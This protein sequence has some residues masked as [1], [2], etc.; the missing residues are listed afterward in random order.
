MQKALTK[1][2]LIY[3]LNGIFRLSA[4]AD[5]AFQMLSDG[6]YVK[7]YT[8]DLNA[9]MNDTDVHVDATIKAILNKITADDQGNIYYDTHLLC[10]VSTQ[11]GNAIQQLPD[12][13]FVTDYSTE[14]QQHTDHTNDNEIHV[15]QLDKDTW[16]QML[17]D[18]KVFTLDEIQKLKILEIRPVSTLPEEDD[19][20]ETTIYL[21]DNDPECPEG[22]PCTMN[23]YIMG[24]WIKLGVTN[25]IL[26]HYVLKTDAQE[27]IDNSHVHDNQSVIDKFTENENGELLY[28]GANIH[29]IG[30]SSQDKNAAQLINGQLYVRDYTEE[31]KTMQIS[32]AFAKINLLDYELTDSGVYELK[33]FIDNYNILLVE[34]YYK[35]NDPQDTPGCAKTAVIDTDVLNLLYE[36]GIDYMLEYGYGILVSN[37]KIRMHENKIWINYYHNVCVYRITGIR[38]GDDS[39]E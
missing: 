16:N 33:D 13:I 12:G 3:I 39:N 4:Q 31:I 22:C 5:N 34:Y 9:H 17:A 32:A 19:I 25:T 14:I 37:S 2:D 30:V 7:D 15:T 26:N 28:D 23:M 1:D 10:R 24:Q 11:A 8:N 20:S 35:P 38:K 29:D 18:A 36:K 21:L 6:L 27:A